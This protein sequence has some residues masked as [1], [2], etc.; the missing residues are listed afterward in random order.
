VHLQT[1]N[2]SKNNIATK[3]AVEPVLGYKSITNLDLG[4][5]LLEDEAV[6]D[7]FTKMPNLGTLVLKGN[8]VVSDTR[9]Y[10]RRMVNS[11]PQLVYLDDRPVFKEE[12]LRAKAWQEG[13]A[14]AERKARE[15]LRHEKKAE[16]VRHM[17]RFRAWQKEQLAA[18]QARRAA[19][20]PEP[21]PCV[22][23]ET[24][25]TP[26][27]TPEEL[28]DYL[29]SNVYDFKAKDM[30]DEAKQITLST[31]RPSLKQRMAQRK[32]AAAA[33]AAKK[34]SEGAAKNAQVAETDAT[35]TETST[36]KWT[37]ETQ[38]QLAN[39]VRTKQFDF[40]AVAKSLASEIN[41]PNLTADECRLKWCSLDW[42]KY[43]KKCGLERP[44]SQKAPASTIVEQKPDTSS[45]T[46]LKTDAEASATGSEAEPGEA[47]PPVPPPT[48][49]VPASVETD[50]GFEETDMD[51]LD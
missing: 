44:A 8:K 23:Y 48:A 30:F 2:L 46:A 33:A 41:W 34:K 27:D 18:M 4:V 25:D 9:N 22:S 12:R 31:T 32:A 51:E 13:G 6:L 10:R 16:A 11:I 7:M 3:E 15:Q 21:E 50:L 5:N 28:D 26:C 29:Q 37:E 14:S 35:R 24:A 40:E 42:E 38:M 47:R 49:P 1:L 36:S 39:L 17:K 43:K 45:S 20:M 19:G